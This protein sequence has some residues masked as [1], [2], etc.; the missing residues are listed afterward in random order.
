MLSATD[1]ILCPLVEQAIPDQLS[2]L[3]A[4]RVLQLHG[5]LHMRSLPK[6]AAELTN[7]SYVSILNI[8]I[9]GIDVICICWLRLHLVIPECN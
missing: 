6:V 4:L 9:Q 2:D 5:N 8:D 1:H 7:L 3:K